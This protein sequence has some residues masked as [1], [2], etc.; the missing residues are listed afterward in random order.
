MNTNA[1]TAIKRY[2]RAMTALATL[3]LSVG[4]CSS[5]EP[6]PESDEHVGVADQALTAAQCNYFAVNGKVQICHRTASQTKPYTVLKI[7][8]QACVNAHALHAGDYVAVNDPNCQGGGCLPQGAPCDPTL[9]CC[10]GF[11]CTNGTCTP[12]V[13]NHCDPSPCQNGGS[14]VN[15]ANGYTCECPAGYTGTN[16]ET[17]IDECAANPCVHGQCLDGINAYV[18]ECDPGFSGTN[19]ETNVDDC[20]NAPCQNGGTCVDGVNSY[21]CECVNGWNGANCELLQWRFDCATQNPCTAE[22]VANGQFYFAASAGDQYYIQCTEA[23]ECYEVSCAPGTY[24]DV[25][26]KACNPTQPAAICPCDGQPWW[27]FQ[28][29]DACAFNGPLDGNGEALRAYV[30]ADSQQITAGFRSDLVGRCGRTPY[31]NGAVFYGEISGLTPAEVQACGA[32]IEAACDCVHGTYDVGGGCT[33]EQG[34]SGP[35]CDYNGTYCPCQ[36]FPNWLSYSSTSQCQI[37]GSG[38][39]NLYTE[40]GMFGVWADGCSSAGAGS[41]TNLTPQ[42]AQSC[43]DQLLAADAAHANLCASCDGMSCGAGACISDGGNVY[44]YY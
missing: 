6:A 16:C 34:W 44:C 24:W 27:Q 11:S 21:T 3:A 10:D 37:Y 9:P 7:S 19:C 38:T 17:E 22:N 4:A 31:A 41:V 39:T 2:F 30:T 15:D 8:E 1:M 14:C 32:Q 29:R 26:A 35:N 20:A 23:L 33:C 43:M 18:C 12:N 36:Q 40:T 25:S 5:V 42:Q 13:S 28:N